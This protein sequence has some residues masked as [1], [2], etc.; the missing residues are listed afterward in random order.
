M[1][2]RLRRDCTL[3]T[4]CLPA[5]TRS[6]E[7]PNMPGAAP[8]SAAA[9]W[10][11]AGPRAVSS[12]NIG[13]LPHPRNG[14]ATI[15]WRQSRRAH[16]AVPWR[17]VIWRDGELAYPLDQCLPP[18]RLL[19]DQS[20]VERRRI[21]SEDSVLDALRGWVLTARGYCGMLQSVACKGYRAWL[22]AVSVSALDR[23]LRSP[24]E[25]A[26]GNRHCRLNQDQ[27]RH[28]PG[29]SGRPSGSE[30]AGNHVPL[31][32]RETRVDQVSHWT[33][34]QAE[35][36]GPDVH[37]SPASCGF[38]LPKSSPGQRSVRRT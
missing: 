8:R 31:D 1:W 33:P 14:L 13:H 34:R 12:W 25:L 27:C 38:G 16:G 24:R 20:G 26:P 5:G 23:D 32:L 6:G 22:Q 17:Q 9:Q 4:C 30:K 11:N 37:V 2:L 7:G 28:C 19:R 15:P 35:P 21:A 18:L 3:T 29:T 36:S 10:P